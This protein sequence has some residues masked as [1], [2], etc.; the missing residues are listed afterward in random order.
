MKHLIVLFIF[1]T[2]FLIS[3]TLPPKIVS[4]NKIETQTTPEFIEVI[5]TLDTPKKIGTYMKNNFEGEIHIFYNLTPYELYKTKKGD[6]Q[7]A[8][9]FSMFIANYHGYEVYKMLV[10]EKTFSWHVLTIYK[11]KGGYTFTDVFT[12]NNTV[13]EKP[14]DVLKVSGDK[15]ICYT[16]FDYNMNIIETVYK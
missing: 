14:R 13:W 7:D 3:C 5:K 10:K 6:C 1:L 15:W 11:E 16:L 9:A 8:C 2:L 12:Y 4:I